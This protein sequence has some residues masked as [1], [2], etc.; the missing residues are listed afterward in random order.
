MLQIACLSF[1]F[2]VIYQ[3]YGGIAQLVRALRWHR[4][5]HKFESYCL[6]QTHLKRKFQVFLYSRRNL[7]C[8]TYCLSFVSTKWLK[9]GGL[10]HPHTQSVC[11]TS[12]HKWRSAK[13]V[14]SLASL[15][16]HKCL[17]VLLSPPKNN[18]VRKDEIFFIQTEGLVC[19]QCKALY[20]ITLACM[21]YAVRF[22]AIQNDV[23]YCSF[24]KNRV[25]QRKPKSAWL[26]F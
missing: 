1:G 17:R 10:H 3:C 18:L 23:L 20:V 24:D 21:W 5:G 19:Y 16:R 25:K 4:R 12:S 6:H 22:D 2:G 11:M 13:W 14:N 26:G 7:C 8:P 9:Q 15:L